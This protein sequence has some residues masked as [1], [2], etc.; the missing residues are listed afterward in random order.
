[1]I[2]R[3]RSLAGLRE[4]H[5]GASQQTYAKQSQLTTGA[6][7]WVFGDLAGTA[8]DARP[9]ADSRW[10][11]RRSSDEGD[12]V[13]LRVFATPPEARI[14]HERGT[15]RLIRLVM[16][17]DLKPLRRDLAVN[18]QGEM[19]YSALAAHPLLNPDL[20]AGRDLRDDLLDR[21]VMTVFL[22]GREPLRSS[23]AFDA[24]IATNARRHRAA[25]AG[26]LAP[27]AGR[28]RTS[29][30]HPDG[31]AARRRAPTAADIRA[32]LAWLVP[33]GFPADHAGGAAAGVPA[34]TCRPSS[35]GSRSWPAIR[36]AMRNSPRRSRRSRP[37]TASGSRSNAASKPPGEDEFRWMLEEFRV[38]LFAQALKTRVPVSARRL[39]DAWALRERASIV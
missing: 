32:Q 27:R 28:A 39:T 18:V 12:S 6:R 9:A 36:A 17:R 31:A 25:R 26:D 20:V 7:T 10:D 16:A 14:S 34:L 19:V 23:A 3:S 24:R 5:A 8:G 35:S 11:I 37:A 33:A 21:V 30:P 1:M 2:A 22:D 4:R 38:S 13:G 15:A 29:V